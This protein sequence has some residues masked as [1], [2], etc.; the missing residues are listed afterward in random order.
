[1][2]Q[3]TSVKYFNHPYNILPLICCWMIY[4]KQMLNHKKQGETTIEKNK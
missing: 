1:M 2:I 3:Q 4:F